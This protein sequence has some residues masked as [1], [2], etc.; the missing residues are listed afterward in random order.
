MGSQLI[1]FKGE[2]WRGRTTLITS[3]RGERRLVRIKNGYVSADGGEIRSFPG[4]RTLVDLSE[5]NNP[6]GGYSRYVIDAVRPVLNTPSPTEFYVEE[7]EGGTSAQQT[8]FARAK[9]IWFEAFEQVG[10]TLV[11]M[12]TTRFR[13]VPIFTA[14]RVRVTPTAVVSGS[15]STGNKLK[16]TLS[17]IPG[18]VSDSDAEGASL[19]G[20]FF[21]DPVYLEGLHTGVPAID[22]IL[23]ASVNGRVHIISASI[24]GVA[25]VLLHTQPG[26]IPSTALTAGEIHTVRPNRS[27]VYPTP[28]GAD[29]FTTSIDDRIDD[30]NALTA[31][32]IVGSPLK[33]TSAAFHVCH[34]AWVANRQRDFGDE[35]GNFSPGLPGVVPFGRAEGI[36]VGGEAGAFSRGVSKREQ[37]ELPYRIVP[38]PAGDRIIIAAPGYNCLF[39]IPM[40][41]PVN[42]DNW[43]SDPDNLTLGVS[44][45][46]NDIYDKPRALG[47]PKCRL[48]DAVFA[49][50]PSSPDQNSFTANFNHLIFALDASPSYGFPPGNYRMCA[51]YQDDVTGEEGPP[52]EIIEVEVPSNGFA[53]QIT[54]SYFHPGYIMPECLAF[55]LNVYMSAP[56]GDALGFYKSFDLKSFGAHAQSFLGFALDT[57]FSVGDLADLSGKYGFNSGA[58]PDNFSRVAEW[59]TLTLP[60]PLRNVESSPSNLEFDLG[61]DFFRPPVEVGMPRGASCARFIRGIMLAVGHIGNR[62]PAENLY[63]QHGTII[64][65]ANR[66]STNSSKKEILIAIHGNNDYLTYSDG[67]QEDG[68][69][70]AS[71]AFPDSC[72]GIEGISEDLIPTGLGRF[73]Q[74]DRVLNRRMMRPDSQGFVDAARERL[75][76]INPVVDDDYGTSPED[77][78]NV[79]VTRSDRSYFLR[80]FTG[81]LQIG[82]PGQPGR[83]TKAGGIGITLLDPN[84]DSDC[85]SIFQFA[86]NAIICSRKET[87]FFSWSRTPGGEI[88]TVVNTEFGCISPNGMVEFDGGVAWLSE[89]GPVA[90]G[91]TLQFIGGDIQQDFVGASKKYATDSKG[92]MRHTWACHDSARGLVMWGLISAQATHSVPDGLGGETFLGIA[93]DGQLSRMACDVVLIWSYR[94][95]SFST[96]E[97]P[98]GMEILWMRQITARDS[99]QESSSTSVMAF[100]AADGRIYSLDDAWSDTNDGCLQT[101]PSSNAEDSVS[102]P[103]V[104]TL[105]STDGVANGGQTARSTSSV[106]GGGGLNFL[107][108]PGHIIQAMDS[109]GAF[110]WETTIAS[111]DPATNTVTLAVAQTWATTDTVRIGVRPAMIVETTFAGGEGVTDIEAQAVHARYTLHGLDNLASQRT[112]AKVEVLKSDLSTGT[113]PLAVQFGEVEWHDFG[114]TGTGRHAR[115]RQ[116]HG[117]ATAPEMAVRMTFTSEAQV[118]IADIALEV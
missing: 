34:P 15:F 27:D 21:G 82:D 110:L 86:G 1:S 118:R 102:M 113:D 20:V 81:Q 41:I 9:P 29:P 65:D 95:N 31:W 83:V 70:L 85:Q 77:P 100:L 19:N 17:G 73:F 28:S 63:A 32:R 75:S 37:L 23:D 92:M 5:E 64:L 35:P 74:I 91:A 84:K 26:D 87:F 78:S 57:S 3:D 39:Q 2:G 61:I 48:V 7:Y 66:D 56:N 38:E 58:S 52:S 107:V 46:G 96:W 79:A 18:D 50:A 6:D 108:R 59:R 80:M 112:F 47:V 71:R 101:S 11:I 8:M 33:Q 93:D 94:S 53:Y 104:A 24:G 60:L 89:R 109:D 69:A 68:F 106:A 4:W 117:M 22:S 14:G 116:V 40:M 25:S 45:F 30:K 43:P 98:S 62:G 90:M 103:L 99:N 49:T 44:W 97:P 76:T 114:V 42:P 36:L 67:G 55:R 115:R 16:I 111:A 88:P 13:E 72:Q 54:I 12:G 105:W 10:E 51:T